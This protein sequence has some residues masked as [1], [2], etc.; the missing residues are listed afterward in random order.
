MLR[1]AAR[2][3]FVL[4]LPVQGFAADKIN[5]EERSASKQGGYGENV[6]VRLS[7]KG[8]PD[9]IPGGSFVLGTTN[10]AG[11]IGS[12]ASCTFEKN[13]GSDPDYWRNERYLN[14]GDGQGLGFECAVT[15]NPAVFYRV[16]LKLWVYKVAAGSGGG[17]R[18]VAAFSNEGLGGGTVAIARTT[19]DP[20]P[21]SIRVCNHRGGADIDVDYGNPRPIR[22]KMHAC[23]EIDRP[24][25]IFFRTP[26]TVSVDEFGAYTLFAPGTFG[27]RPRTGKTTQNVRDKRITVSEFTPASATC[28]EPGPGEPFDRTSYWGWCK[29]ADL[30]EGK[31]YRVCVDAGYSNQDDKLEY[32]G[33]LLR[34]ILDPKL[35][36][37][38]LGDNPDSYQY[39]SVAPKTCRD[40]F[41]VSFAAVL[42]FGHNDWNDQSVAKFKY[43]YAEIPA[44]AP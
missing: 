43:R 15:P 42:V 27:K 5:C 44:P 7:E 28:A 31:N 41:G 1:Y 6:T 3:L 9:L 36:Q 35:A 32:P 13:G 18:T 37:K 38:K 29:L 23:L 21:Y 20:V 25:R 8:N 34:I 24:E 2:L 33:S 14:A 19:R 12:S 4:C 30:K 16:V 26:E 10:S 17:D 39:M 40:L 11:T 22:V